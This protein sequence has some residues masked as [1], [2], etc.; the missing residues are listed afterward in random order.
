MIN[1]I[2]ESYSYITIDSNSYN[3]KGELIANSNKLDFNK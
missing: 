3:L 1:N 2:D